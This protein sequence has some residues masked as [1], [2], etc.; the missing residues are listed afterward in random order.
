MCSQNSCH[1]YHHKKSSCHI[2]FTHVFSTALYFWSNKIGWLRSYFNA[3]GNAV[4]KWAFTFLWT[5]GIYDIT[6]LE[7]F[8]SRLSIK[9]T[10]FYSNSCCIALFQYQLKFQFLFFCGETFFHKITSI[11]LST[12]VILLSIC[13]WH[14]IINKLHARTN[15]FYVKIKFHQS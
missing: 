11:G 3:W 7:N 14:E 1:R 2:L 6:F 10:E 13:L 4:S 15:L 8:F 5:D 12:P 9:S